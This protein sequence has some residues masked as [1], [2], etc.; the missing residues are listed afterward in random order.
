[1]VMALR[2][3]PAFFSVYTVSLPTTG[4]LETAVTHVCFYIMF[5]LHL[6]QIKHETIMQLN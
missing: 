6:I 2:G 1:M 5:H 4:M 3:V